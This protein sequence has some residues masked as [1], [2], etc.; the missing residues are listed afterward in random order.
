MSARIRIGTRGSTLALWQANEL[1]ARL[2]ERGYRPELH[3]VKTTGD[4]RQDVSLAL[5]CD[6]GW[7]ASHVLITWLANLRFDRLALSWISGSA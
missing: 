1:S 3:I 2:S 5:T 7:R 4:K 6:V